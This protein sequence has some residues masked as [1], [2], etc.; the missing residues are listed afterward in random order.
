MAGGAM[1]V[2]VE[3]GVVH[4]DLQPAADEQDQEQEIDVMGDAQPGREAVRLR[5]R[6]GSKHAVGRQCRK[7][8]SAPLN[9][10]RRD[11][12]Q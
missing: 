4:E 12:E 3:A 7:T 1:D 10:S 6:C 11:Q 2:P 5:R 8:D 9:V